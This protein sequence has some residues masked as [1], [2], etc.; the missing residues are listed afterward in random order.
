MRYT[1]LWINRSTETSHYHLDEQLV[2]SHNKKCRGRRT[3]QFKSDLNVFKAWTYFGSRTVKVLNMQFQNMVNSINKSSRVCFLFQLRLTDY[4]SIVILTFT[5]P[6]APRWEWP[7][8]SNCHHRWKYQLIFSLFG[9]SVDAW[10]ERV[11]RGTLIGTMWPL[12]LR[13]T[14]GKWDLRA[15]GNPESKIFSK[16]SLTN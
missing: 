12:S 13:L 5:R 3:L 11:F 16:N 14:E 8:D 15:D 7:K 2:R 6:F 9:S 1:F 4:P 10:G